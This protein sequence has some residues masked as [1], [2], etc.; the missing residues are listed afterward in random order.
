MRKFYEKHEVLFAVLWIVLYCVTMA[1]VKERFGYGSAWMLL[2]LAAF[3]TGITA[4]VKGWRLE[5]KYG[6]TGWP[7]PMK[8]Y[9]FFI[10]MWIL[11]TGNLWD[12][13]APSHEGMALV[14]ATLSMILVGYVEEMLFRGF[15]FKAMLGNGRAVVAI[16]VSA[17]TFGMGHIINLFTGQAG[18]DTVMQMLFAVAW[19]FLFTMVFYRSGSLIPCII[20][21]AMI[22]VF[23][24]YGADV[25]WVDALYMGATIVLAAA[26]CVYLARQKSDTSRPAGD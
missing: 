11:A 24:Q 7:K 4:V 6:L 20:A 9:L 10:P 12:G 13:L 17:L 19:G 8:R 22:D 25:E 1:P 18:F 5:G 15:L 3:A 14:V 2:L 23:A 26:Y 21:H 16:V